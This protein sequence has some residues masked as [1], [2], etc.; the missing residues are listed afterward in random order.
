MVPTRGAIFGD[1]YGGDHVRCF[2][3][4]PLTRTLYD[5][6]AS[7]GDQENAGGRLINTLLMYLFVWL[8]VYGI[9]MIGDVIIFNLIEFWSGDPIEISSTETRDG[10][11]ITQ[12]T[13]EDGETL[14]MT[15]SRDGEVF[16]SQYFVRHPDGTI[17][18]QNA[19]RVATGEI[20]KGDDGGFRFLGLDGTE[21]TLV[22]GD[23]LAH[24][25]ASRQ[26]SQVSID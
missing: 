8:P 10:V 3:S 6:N 18:V 25:V 26:E 24:L 5:F 1:R 15:L 19:E 23:D 12:R 14:E 22:S 21:A 16:A 20:R 11:T 9:A 7:V 2:G 13:I 4:F 17:E